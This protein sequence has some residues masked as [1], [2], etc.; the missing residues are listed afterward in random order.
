M[1]NPSN[2]RKKLTV[3]QDLS[4]TVRERMKGEWQIY[5]LHD[6]VHVDVI[7]CEIVQQHVKM[8]D[9]LCKELHIG[10]CG[11]YFGDYAAKHGSQ[12][13]IQQLA[14][15]LKQRGATQVSLSN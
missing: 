7:T 6:M 9:E 8:L 11:S 13:H 10:I 12:K 14:D 4:F 1:K 3:F 15:A 2:D 5:V